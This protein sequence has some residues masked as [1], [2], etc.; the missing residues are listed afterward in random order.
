[1]QSPSPSV[2][3]ASTKKACCEEA[4]QASHGL[5]WKCPTC[6]SLNLSI[7]TTPT[8]YKFL[9]SLADI[10]WMV[11]SQG[12]G[13]TW[14][15]TVSMLFHAQAQETGR[16][17]PVTGAKLPIHWAYIRDTHQNIKLVSIPYWKLNFPGLFTFREDSHIMT[18]PGLTVDLLGM[19]SEA[20]TTKIQGGEY[21]GIWIE[22]PAPIMTSGLSGTTVNVGIPHGVFR[23]CLARQRGAGTR[24]R[25]QLTMNPADTSHWTY[26]EREENPPPELVTEVCKTRPGENPHITDADRTRV[27]MAFR[28]RPDLYARYV[29]GRESE[30]YPGIAITPE[31][32][33]DWHKAAFRLD[34]ILGAQ[35][36]IF[37]D[38]GLNPTAMLAQIVPSGRLHLLDCVTLEHQGMEQLIEGKLI[39]LLLSPRWVRIR[40]FR[41]L[42]DDS[43]KNREQ[44][45]SEFSAS[46]VIVAKLVKWLPSGYEGGVQHWD[47]RRDAIKTLL[48]GNLGGLPR[49]L[50]NPAVTPGEP[51]NRIHALLAGGYC[52]Q[53]TNGVVQ[54]DGPYKNLH[55]HPGDALTHSVA[56]LFGVPPQPTVSNKEEIGRQRQQAR[57]YSAGTI[58]RV[59]PA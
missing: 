22:E 59:V 11:G 17:D 35:S 2:P 48:C 55:S 3:P 19:D 57:S 7:E 5:L 54:R 44:S 23:A 40:A 47:L 28:D 18:A 39:P 49:L 8:Q 6:G 52:Y 34:P 58:Q 46:R 10:I 36:F 45:N 30:V 41:A 38:G 31:Y 15:G 27:R 14:I 24:K 25:L 12:E 56:K 42:G 37:F 53:V 29:L 51:F 32:N 9:T 33:P 43:L 4:S 21:D 13:K 26:K 1:M 16:T 50:V 20:D